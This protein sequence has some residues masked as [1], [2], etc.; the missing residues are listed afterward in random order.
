M[1]TLSG[2]DHQRLHETLRDIYAT[3]DLEDFPRVVLSCLDELIGSDMA[4]YNEVC[5]D[6]GRIVG[7]ISPDSYTAEQLSEK[8][9]PFLSEHPLIA[10][11]SQKQDNASTAISDLL[12]RRDWHQTAIYNEFFRPLSIEDQMAIGLK[13]E[14]PWIFGIALNRARRSFSQRDRALLEL[15]RPHLVQAHANAVAWTRLKNQAQNQNQQSEPDTAWRLEVPSRQENEP[16]RVLVVRDNGRL[17][18]CSDRARQLLSCYFGAIENRAPAVIAQWLHDNLRSHAAHQFLL[19]TSTTF[20]PLRIQHAYRTLLVRCGEHIEGQ[21]LLLLEEAIELQSAP[22]DFLIQSLMAHGLTRR[23]SEVLW[24]LARGQNNEQIALEM[25]VSSH[26]VKRHLEAIYTKMGV[27]GRV[28]A[29]HRARQ[30]M[31]HETDFPD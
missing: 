19:L 17:V 20:T 16:N 3:R 9:E 22:F 7:L 15:L 8:L 12:S 10:R 14:A 4:S 29:A 2:S 27:A 6:E 5:L 25:G 26:T 1:S 31:K 30:W 23:Q 28:A 21:T 24:H 18:F 13:N 11:F